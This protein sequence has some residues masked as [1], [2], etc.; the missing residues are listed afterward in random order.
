MNKLALFLTAFLVASFVAVRTVDLPDE[1]FRTWLKREREVRELT[2]R[3]ETF[4]EIFEDTLTALE[5]GVI[6]LKTARARVAE[7]ARAYNPDH[8]VALGQYRYPGTTD[9][10]RVGHNLVGHLQERA[11]L[12]PKLKQ[13]VEKLEMELAEI[14]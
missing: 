5:N 7:A 13:R 4:K 11:E 9:E 2:I 12:N 10:E 8:L 1:E 14:R 3:Y 6:D